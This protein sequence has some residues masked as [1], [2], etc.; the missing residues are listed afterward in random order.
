MTILDST[1][2]ALLTYATHSFAACGIALIAARLLRRPQDRD[3]V[4]KTALLAPIATTAIAMT[5][6]AGGARSPFIDLATLARRASPTKLPG[7]LVR[8]RV[9]REGDV[10]RVDRWFSDPV[11]TA[12]STGALA[13][14]LLVVGAASTRLIVRRRRLARAVG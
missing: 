5:L 11:T 14:A 7:R 1:A 3:V 10:S 12:L 4:W 6:S 9:L 2:T 13:V 8:V